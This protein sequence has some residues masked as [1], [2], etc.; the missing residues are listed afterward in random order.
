MKKIDV[1]CVH[2]QVPKSITKYSHKLAIKK[3]GKYLCLSC[4]MK[5]PSISEKNSIAQKARFTIIENRQKMSQS[6]KGYFLDHEALA[7]KSET[8]T[9]L[10]ESQEYREKRSTAIRELWQDRPYRD[11][12]INGIKESWTDDRKAKQSI[13]STDLWNDPLY[14]SIQHQARVEMWQSPEY[15]NNQTAAT[16]KM[17]ESAKYR[18]KQAI[19]L[20]KAARTSILDKILLA[21][22]QQLGFNAG[23]ISLG[24]W[25]FDCYVTHN[26][27][28]LLIEAQGDY[29][30]N[31][32]ERRIRDKQ[33]FSYYTKYLANDYELLIVWEHEFYCIGKIIDKIRGK[34]VPGNSIMRYAIKDTS[35]QIVE[36]VAAE[37]FYNCHHYLKKSRPGI[38]IGATYNSEIIACLTYS[39][40]TRNESAIKF[41]LQS[42]EMLELARLSVN[43]L[44]RQKNL[45][46]YLISRSVKIIKQTRPLVKLLISFADT[47][48][49]HTG[50]VYKASGWIKDGVAPA[51]YWYIDDKAKYRH[52]KTVWDQA[53]RLGMSEAEYADYCKL[54][55]INGKHLLRF[56]KWL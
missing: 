51:T 7:K 22:C 32:K 10:W 56:I 39:S 1:C 23:P 16:K 42:S 20:S 19:A 6:L 4:V 3:H 46:S 45:C 34:L 9:K 14:Q 15:R 47:T 28:K 37:T 12:I 2:C 17:W 11:S 44:Y 21:I 52:K 24:P 18:E 53:K 26:D 43:Q 55:K 13:I 40:L 27:K 30:H 5:L 48:L 33:K 35:I 50:A 29:W 31:K 54:T 49:G 41:D 38:H 36:R 8:T 25:A